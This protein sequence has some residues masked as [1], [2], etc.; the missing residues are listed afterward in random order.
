MNP[1]A[2]QSISTLDPCVPLRLD[3]GEFIIGNAPGLFGGSGGD[4][5]RE[6]VVFDVETTGLSWEN[7]EIIQV[8]GVKIADGKINREKAF[9]SYVKP[10]H[11][12][13]SFITRLTGVT[14]ARVSKA[15]KPVEALTRFSNFCGDAILVAHNGHVFDMRFIRSVCIKNHCPVRTVR[16]LDTMHVSWRLWGRGRGV[17]HSLDR[18]RG[19]LRVSTKGLK[20][21]DARGD[22]EILARCLL[23][24]LV[25]LADEKEG[26]AIS[27]FYG[28]LPSGEVRNSI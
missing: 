18:V 12:I 3:A 19:R 10:R 11:K 23:K 21:H 15:P 20:R 13:P 26:C 25:H 2:I 4:G 1:T 14:N 8:A 9:F 7:D 16:Y 5:P 24:M 27:T 6:L 17:S 28:F 22:V